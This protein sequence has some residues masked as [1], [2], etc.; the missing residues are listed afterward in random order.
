MESFCFVQN[1]PVAPLFPKEKTDSFCSSCGLNWNNFLVS[2]R[3]GCGDC[4]SSFAAPLEPLMKQYHGRMPGQNA[5]SFPYEHTPHAESRTEEL[6]DYV[7]KNKRFS[8]RKGADVQFEIKSIIASTTQLESTY[9]PSLK[10]Q[11][12]NEKPKEERVKEER[13]KEDRIIESVR[14]RVARNINTL[15]Y[16]TLLNAEEKGRLS[17][18]LAEPQ[19]ILRQSLTYEPISV[20]IF[21]TDD[22]DHLRVIWC[23][24]WESYYHS[25]RMIFHIQRLIY[26]LD[27]LYCWDFHPDYGFC[28]ACPALAGLS[29]RISFQMKIP[30]L[31]KGGNWP[32]WTESLEKAGCEIRGEDSE[33]MKKKDMMKRGRVQISGRNWG[34]DT[35]LAENFARLASLMSR[36]AEAEKMANQ[37]EISSYVI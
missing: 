13:G 37:G 16:L 32:I 6:L 7:L 36:L 29:V 30:T 25:N 18:F 26:I 20:P 4:Y 2:G 15:P 28:T 24:P 33:F 21:L 27:S 11:K 10:K 19:G 9:S 12:L 23:F 3:L 22:E 35:E 31:Y 5:F 1:N 14:I 34:F 8:K 17:R